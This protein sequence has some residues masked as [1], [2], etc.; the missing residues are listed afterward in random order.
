MK[1]VKFIFLMIISMFVMF[2]IFTH[3][4]T[5]INNNGV[6]MTEEEYNNFLKIHDQRYVMLM[7]EEDYDRLKDLDYSDVK[8][9]TKY[10]VSTYNEHLNLTAEREISKEEYGNFGNVASPLLDNGN[11]YFA[12]TAKSI[13]IS[14]MGGNNWN[15]VSV[16]VA[17]KGIP[18]TRSFDVMG[19]RGYGFEFRN[20]SQIG[21]QIY[22]LNGSYKVIDYS[23]NGTNIKRLDNGFGISMNIVN[24]DIDDLMLSVECDVTPTESHPTI[25]G[26]YQHAVQN[27]S[28]TESQNYYLGIAGLG[29]VFVFPYNTSVKY[30][31]MTGVRIEY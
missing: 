12:S 29:N 10:T 23:W 14:L 30:D 7:T 22:K 18:K 15:Y 1:N 17:W 19:I 20:G 2:P 3:A 26:S 31:G 28:L 8:K 5:I 24:D 21:R 11:N 16:D 13:S 6:E 25:Y 9:E 27:V 4:K